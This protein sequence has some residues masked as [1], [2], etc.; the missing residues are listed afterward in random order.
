MNTNL[1]ACHGSA[2]SPNVLPKSKGEYDL[3]GEG[4]MLE[5]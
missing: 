4:D 2:C 1:I 3:I 5:E